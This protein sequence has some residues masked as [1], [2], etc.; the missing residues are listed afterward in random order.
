M[1]SPQLEENQRTAI[2]A[3]FQAIEINPVNLLK[4]KDSIPDGYITKVFISKAFEGFGPKDLTATVI[5]DCI[6]S[7]KTDV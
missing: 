5:K 6:E 3:L 1:S 2:G 4:M 7:I